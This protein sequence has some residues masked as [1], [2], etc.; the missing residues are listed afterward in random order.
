M[1]TPAYL[2][3]TPVCKT[4]IQHYTYYYMIK[5]RKLIPLTEYYKNHYDNSPIL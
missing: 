4:Q 2:S 1:Y 5:W 3:A